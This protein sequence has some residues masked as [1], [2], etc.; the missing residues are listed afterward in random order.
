M[1]RLSSA[2]FSAKHDRSTCEYADIFRLVGWDVLELVDVEK[3]VGRK[4]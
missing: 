4:S 3:I 2:L 1:N